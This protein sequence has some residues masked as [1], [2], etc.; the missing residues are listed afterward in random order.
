[1]HPA[2]IATAL[3]NTLHYTPKP[4]PEPEPELNPE[5]FALQALVAVAL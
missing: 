3:H 5:A 1:L 4:D 2:H